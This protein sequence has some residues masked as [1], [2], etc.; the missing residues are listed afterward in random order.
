[1]VAQTLIRKFAV[2]AVAGLMAGGAAVGTA[3]AAPGGP[4]HQEQ[5]VQQ[6]RLVEQVLYRGRVIART[7]L[8]VRTG[9]GV[10]YP[11]KPPAV[12]YGTV[13]RIE[14]KVEGGNVGGN[15]LWYKLKDSRFSRGYVAARYVENVGAAPHRCSRAGH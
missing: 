10:N 9:P 5:Q 11:A 12:P 4:V 6:V 3:Q 7:G 15:R 14:C 1:M 2:T 13:V 8:K